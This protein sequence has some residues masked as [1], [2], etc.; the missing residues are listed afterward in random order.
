MDPFLSSKQ[1]SI[2]SKQVQALKPQSQAMALGYWESMTSA[3]PCAQEGWPSKNN[4]ESLRCV[5]RG[6]QIAYSTFK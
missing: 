4:A 5:T 2:L 6:K 3:K 1:P